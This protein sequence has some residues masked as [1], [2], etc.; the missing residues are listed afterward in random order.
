MCN[1]GYTM[2]MFEDVILTLSTMPF[3]SAT[4]NRNKLIKI[5]KWKHSFTDI[6]DTQPILALLG[7]DKEFS[8]LTVCVVEV[9]YKHNVICFIF[10]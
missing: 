1:I 3:I 5:I 2:S 9:E 7:G 10:L 6:E 8:V 4:G